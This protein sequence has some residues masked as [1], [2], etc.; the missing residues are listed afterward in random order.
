MQTYE[1]L[2]FSLK[3]QIVVAFTGDVIYNNFVKLFILEEN[4][5]KKIL[6][7]LMAVLM[8]FSALSVVAM[9]EETTAA[10]TIVE[11]N[12]SIKNDDGLVFPENFTQLVMSVFV[13]LFET[14]VNFFS[15]I[16]ENI[17]PDVDLDQELAN[18]AGSIGDKLDGF[19]S[20]G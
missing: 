4:P 2:Y 12:N 7:V 10:E 13:K 16:I 17:F 6:A 3:L 18:G 20:Q 8:A 11:N 9:A 5:M 14:V 1:K 19:L 15:S